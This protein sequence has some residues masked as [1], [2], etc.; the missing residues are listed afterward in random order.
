MTLE[1]LK[2][3]VERRYGFEISGQTRKRKVVYAR[4]VFCKL[5]RLMEYTFQ[6][7]GNAIGV[8]HCSALYHNNT[9]YSVESLDV[10]IYNKIK[11]YCTIKKKKNT[12]DIILILEEREAFYK[13][14]IKKLN[15]KISE[16]E[17]QPSSES[18]LISKRIDDWDFE[19]KSEFINTRLAPFERLVKSR[20]MRREPVKVQGAKIERRV[21]NPFLQ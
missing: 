14:K 2:Q 9:F 15:K 21:K 7:I 11:T 3:E 6:D 17:S 20:V 19:T 1:Q 10:K 16:L 13:S 4:K 18:Q 12:K 8:N 5:G